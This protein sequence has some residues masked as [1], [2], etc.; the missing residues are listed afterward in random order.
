[1]GCEG[2]D[3]CSTE[4]AGLPLLTTCPADD[5][6]MLFIN[7]VGGAGK[8]KYAI[9]TWAKVKECIGS[10]AYAAL[11]A[12]IAAQGTTY[13][14][15]DLIGASEVQFIIVNKQ[16]YTYE[17]GDFAF[18]DNTGTVVFITITLFVGDKIVIPYKSA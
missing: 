18:N 1:M 17:D 7:A 4:L 13:Q 14:N 2:T 8:Y 10:G 6:R 16:L 12:T 15:D 9:R 11:P 5:E 3:Q